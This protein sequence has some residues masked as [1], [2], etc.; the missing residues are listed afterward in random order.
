MLSSETEFSD[1]TKIICFFKGIRIRKNQGIQLDPD[2]IL[3]DS[4]SSGAGAAL[5]VAWGE[6][7]EVVPDALLLRVGD[8]EGRH[9]S[10]PHTQHHA[11]A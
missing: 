5:G 3:V 9:T 1:W 6:G 11:P 8:G 7:L 2:L 4:T 10:I